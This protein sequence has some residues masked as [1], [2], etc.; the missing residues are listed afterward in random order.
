MEK[1][2]QIEEMAGIIDR[3]KKPCDCLCVSECISKHPDCKL[4]NRKEWSCIAYTKAEA[5]YNAGYQKAGEIRKEGERSILFKVNNERLLKIEQ[6]ESNGDCI[7]TTVANNGETERTDVISPGDF[8]MLI[9]YY[10]HQKEHG[11]EIF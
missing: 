8:V 9:N 11:N 4:Q 3:T 7:I 6:L 2:E 10:R 5:L 1:H